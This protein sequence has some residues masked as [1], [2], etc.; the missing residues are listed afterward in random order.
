[1]AVSS[2]GWG[3]S[4][5]RFKSGLPD[6]AEVTHRRQFA[7]NAVLICPG[8]A[9]GGRGRYGAILSSMYRRDTDGAR[10]LDFH[11]QTPLPGD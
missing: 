8:E 6:S 4:G 10:K 9:D 11:Q 5:R 1:M 7:D 3:P 2:P